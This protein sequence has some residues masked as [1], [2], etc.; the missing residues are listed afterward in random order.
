MVERLDLDVAVVGG[1]PAGI[2]AAC[3]AA[4]AGASVVL[5]DEG[6]APGG[7]I[8]RHLPG[9]EAPRTARRW[10]AR[11]QRSGARVV[12]EAAVFDAERSGEE[13]L[14]RALAAGR[15]L[16]VRA[17]RLVLATGA[18]ELFLP[19]PG[20]TLPGIVGVGA[21]QALLKSG[22][23]LAGRTAVVA[24][25]GPLLLAAAASLARAGARV[26]FVAEQAEPEA[27]RRFAWALLGS[28]A[29]L[30]EAALYRLAVARAPYRP[31]FWVKA[32]GGEG[33]V[34]GAHVTNGRRKL[35]I[36]CDLL[37]VGYGLVPNL[38]LPR[39]IGCGVELS[40]PRVS[41]TGGQETSIPGVYAAGE[42]CGIAGAGAAVVEGEI[43]G[44]AASGALR[45]EETEAG[46]LLDARARARAF[47][48]LLASAFRLRPEVLG[49]AAPGTIVC[50][51]EDVPL[52]RLEAAGTL[53]EAK[54]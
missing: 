20:W 54:L 32:A 26:A 50:R 35:E 47:G 10:L 27:V 5:L 41:V 11:L 6:L 2:A 9:K 8:H 39:L 40:P 24:G 29:K 44:L 22:A 45:P 46:A 37:C 53:R 51:C 25:S 3:R 13:W 31:G 43:A 34:E 28:P 49:L 52:S 33:K 12:S 1:G 7:Q 18:R 4:D 48:D 21:A 19:F 15:L 36:A 14:L 17:R 30:L 23:D 16:H 38:E 42:V